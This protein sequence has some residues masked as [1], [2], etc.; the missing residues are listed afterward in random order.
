VRDQ[1]GVVVGQERSVVLEEVEQVRHHLQVGRDVG[2]V[3]EEVHVVEA[4]L[5]HVL[6]AVAQMA[7]A[8]LTMP[9]GGC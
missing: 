8:G 3:T 1:R 6:D 5:D 9:L 4:D 2:V 7:C